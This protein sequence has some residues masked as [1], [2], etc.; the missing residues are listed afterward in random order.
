MQAYVYRDNFVI[1]GVRRE[2]YDFFEH[3]KFHMWAMIEGVLGPDP[4]R[5]VREV[6]CLNCVLR[7]CL[8]M[9][10]RPEA[11][12][13]EADARHVEILVPECQDAGARREKHEQRR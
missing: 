13:I 6:V 5:D 1:K 4:G 8:P 2:L 11:V 9:S 3:L 12:E 10:G 7:W